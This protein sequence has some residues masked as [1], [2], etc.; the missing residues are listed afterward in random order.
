MENVILIGLGLILLFV[1]YK[2]VG[3][4]KRIKFNK[5]YVELFNKVLKEDNERA[6]EDV[7]E[8]VNKTENIEFIP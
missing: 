7:V 1:L 8:Y 3:M 4:Y 5:T 6:Y 2:N